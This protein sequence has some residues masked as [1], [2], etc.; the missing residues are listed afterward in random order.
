MKNSF[1]KIYQTFAGIT[2]IVMLFFAFGTLF[3]K[4]NETV[5]ADECP[6]GLDVVLVVDRSNSMLDDTS[7]STPISAA[8]PLSDVQSGTASFLDRL[9]TSTD[10]VGLVE[11]NTS[12][13]TSSSLTDNFSD[14]RT[15]VNTDW[16]GAGSEGW[17][18]T[19][20]AIEAARAELNA[21][22]R[23]NARK[24]MV[25]ISDGNPGL[26]DEDPADALARAVYS[27]NQAKM[28]GILIYAIGF[29]ANLNENVLDQISSDPASKYYRRAPT[30]SAIAAMYNDLDISISCDNQ[31]PIIILAHNTYSLFVGGSFDPLSGHATSYDFEDGDRTTFMTASSTVNTNVIGNYTVKYNVQDSKGLSADEKTLF[32]EVKNPSSGCTSNCGGGNSLVRSLV[33]TNEKVMYLG[34][35]KATVTWTTNIPA[36]SVVSYGPFS[37]PVA[38]PAPKFGYPL[39]TI[40][41]MTPVIEHSVAISGLQEGVQYWFRPISFDPTVDITVG[42]EVTYTVIPVAPV[43]QPV[44]CNYLLEYIKLGANNNR[45]EVEKLE[46]FLNTYQNENLAVDGVYDGN[47]YDAVTR[48]QKK[49]G[50]EVLT[51]WGYDKSTGYVYITTK[52]KVNEIYCAKP[53]PLDTAQEAE[54]IAFK[55]LLKQI[56]EQQVAALIAAAEAAANAG[57]NGNLVVETLPATTT[58]DYNNIVGLLDDAKGT[59]VPQTQQ[60]G[61]LAAAFL[62][63]VGGFM[64]SYWYLFLLAALVFVA[65]VLFIRT[66]NNKSE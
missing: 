64:T 16:V 25:I 9:N 11:F 26:F 50:G 55:A 3:A 36:S 40:E 27:A 31:K 61:N 41:N 34:E 48:F 19:G 13:I 21:H 52:K 23:T 18:N 33:I 53:F 62:G 4:L 17:T 58:I 42:K 5:L 29:G 35:G 59:N 7:V 57:V 32:V 30:S 39:K 10:K 47:D 46:R 8:Q 63:G 45:V 51:P 65:L 2:I 6:V 60:N 20:A 1:E 38:G 24:V 66:R 12:A 49:Y 14:V 15:K 43:I 28:N 22:G 54:I 37:V 44:A 56:A